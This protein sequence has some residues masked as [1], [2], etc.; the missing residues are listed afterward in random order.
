MANQGVQTVGAGP[1][2]DDF[3]RVP[4]DVER[5]APRRPAAPIP[6]PSTDVVRV[7]PYL[8]ARRLPLAGTT[9]DPVPAIAPGQPIPGA[10]L[11]PA[12][13]VRPAENLPVRAAEWRARIAERQARAELWQVTADRLPVRTQPERATPGAALTR[14]AKPPVGSTA[15]GPRSVGRHSQ[16]A[17]AGGRHRSSRASVE[18][19]HRSLRRPRSLRQQLRWGSVLA[20]TVAGLVAVSAFLLLRSSPPPVAGTT[21]APP[22]RNIVCGIGRAD[23]S[24]SA[25][26]QTALVIYRAAQESTGGD[27]V[28]LQN[29]ANHQQNGIADGQL[30]SAGQVSLRGL[31]LALADWPATPMTS[32]TVTTLRFAMNQRQDGTLKFYLSRQDYD[33]TQPLTWQDLDPAPLA[34]VTGRP[35][36][37]GVY[38]VRVTLPERT[39]RQLLYTVWRRA[40]GAATLS[41]CSDVVLAPPAA[42]GSAAVQTST[43]LAP[44]ATVGRAPASAGTATPVERD[45]PAPVRYASDGGDRRGF[46]SHSGR[47]HRGFGPRSGHHRSRRANHRV[48]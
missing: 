20:L 19:R 4:A 33:P 17:M 21:T 34:Q 11:P 9:V 42:L 3:N 30:C 36:T 45:L 5:L 41:A 35:D 23:R 27:A 48:R 37:A 28:D 29:A 12:P 2:D 31:D 25:A 40:D 26:C 38:R 10:E 47:D 32:R 39:G 24:S 46:R 8:P 22:S 18:R 14:L 16:A 43:R 7:P 13:P 44:S 1:S 6:P 15:G